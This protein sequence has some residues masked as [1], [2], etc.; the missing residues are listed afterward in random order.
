MIQNRYP[1]NDIQTEK[2]ASAIRICLPRI[3]N[4]ELSVEGVGIGTSDW[5]LK[6]KEGKGKALAF[7]SKQSRTSAVQDAFSK[8]LVVVLNDGEKVTAEVNLQKVDP[9]AYN[10]MWDVPNITVNEV[11]YNDHEQESEMSDSDFDGCF[12]QLNKL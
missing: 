3:K 1:I 6:F 12:T 8:L 5:N 2:Y 10:P 7:A 11:S 9:F 4:G